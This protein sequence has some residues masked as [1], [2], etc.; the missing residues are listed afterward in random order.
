MNNQPVLYK[1]LI[2]SKNNFRLLDCEKLLSLF[3]HIFLEKDLTQ[4]GS[5]SVYSQVFGTYNHRFHD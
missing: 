3:G 1:S 5:K 4:S 2:I